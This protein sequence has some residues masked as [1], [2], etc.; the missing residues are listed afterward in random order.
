MS[1]GFKFLLVIRI[2]MKDCVKLFM[3]EKKKLR[4][5]FMTTSARVC[6]TID[7]WTSVQKLNY[8]VITSHFIDSDCNLYKRIFKL[9][10]NS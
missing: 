5:M 4:A 7:M 1:L 6:L 8:M 2:V 9:L 10:F 3:S